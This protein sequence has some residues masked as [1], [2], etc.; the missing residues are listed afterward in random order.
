MPREVLKKMGDNF[1]LG[2]GVADALALIQLGVESL[3]EFRFPSA[4]EQAIETWIGKLGLG[5]K[6]LL[7]T[8][9]V[10]RAWA[11]VGLY[12]RQVEQALEDRPVRLGY[13]A[14]GDQAEGHQAA[15]LETL[16]DAVPSRRYDHIQGGQGDP[17]DALRVQHLASENSSISTHHL[18]EEKEVE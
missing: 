9:R 13:H 6:A 14:W 5:D 15:V 7:M 1:G 2:D 8:A 10:P 17:E 3:Q 18:S 16:Q 11:A 12:Y 4:P